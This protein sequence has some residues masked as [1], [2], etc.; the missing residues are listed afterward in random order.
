ME[1]GAA[2]EGVMAVVA[3]VVHVEAGM[4]VVMEVGMVVVVKV[5]ADS[6]VG[7]VGVVMAEVR[8]ARRL[9]RRHSTALRGQRRFDHKRIAQ[10][11]HPSLRHELQPLVCHVGTLPKPRQTAC[12]GRIHCPYRW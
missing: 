8:A 4:E 7:M 2:T 5:A 9:F 11:C 1:L 10:C 6:V 3:A 12:R